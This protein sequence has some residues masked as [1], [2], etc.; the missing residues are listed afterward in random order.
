[1][2]CPI[3]K[4]LPPPPHGKTGWPWTEESAQVLCMTPNI[5][6]SPSISIVTPN[7]NQSAFLEETIRS[8]LLQGYPNLEYIIIDGGSTDGSV[9]IIKKYQNWLKRWVSES[10]MGQSHAINKGFSTATGE[11]FAYLNS[12]DLYNPNAFSTIAKSFSGANSVHLVVGECICFDEHGILDIFKPSWP[13][14]LKHFLQPFSATFAQPAAFWSNSIFHK[15]A[16]FDEHFNFCFDQEFYLKLGLNGVKPLFTPHKVASYR[17]HR[18][19]KTRSQ[20]C[21]FYLETIKLVNKHAAALALSP[22]QK[23]LALSRIN[24]ELGYLKVFHI[25]KNLG[26]SAALAAALKN[27]LLYPNELFERRT[28]GL[29]RRLLFFTYHNVRELH[30]V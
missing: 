3:L 7:L 28:I 29:L 13:Q 18:G 19:S 1:M 26:R 21:Q 20:R 4:E 5:S 10:D 25:W 14:N 2:R 8:V 16:G 9:E 15:A 6:C 24:G 11:I 30:I 22:R 23:R 17:E 12:N 27:I